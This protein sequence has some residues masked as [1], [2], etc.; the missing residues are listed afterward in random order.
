VTFTDVPFGTYTA[1]EV[2]QE[3]WEVVSGTGVVEVGF[4]EPTITIK[5]KIIVDEEE[6]PDPVH[7]IS[8]V[9]WNDLD[10]DGIK[11]DGEP[12]LSG[13]GI[14]AVSEGSTLYATTS[15][16]G[17]YSFEVGE[18]TWIVSEINK[19]GWTQT[20]LYKNGVQVVLGLETPRSCS[21][22]AATPVIAEAVGAA[23]TPIQYLYTCDFGNKEQEEEVI[24]PPAE[25]T[26]GGGSS[27]S[28]ARSTRPQGQVLGA[29]TQACEIY[30]TEYM[31]Q[32]AVA[33]S[34]QV[35]KLQIF[36]NAVGYTFPVSGVFDDATD[37][38]VRAFQLKYQ[39]EVLTP[40]FKAGI[41]PHNNPTGWVYQLTR[42]KINNIVCPGS[43]AY[44]VLN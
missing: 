25:E 13:W 21:I 8:G 12:N 39:D 22:T 15:V 11:E 9:K 10:G 1:G 16:S 20:G 2:M 19:N 44:P 7:T 32:G 43:E 6:V 4:E 29:S 18:G 30:L 14:K 17:D 42:W 35:T 38:A 27:G 23:P 41:V 31:K 5:N 36:L 40:W 26:G 3:G 33:S 28:R 37:E 34:T 24:V